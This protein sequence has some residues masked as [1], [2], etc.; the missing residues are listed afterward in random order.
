M[1]IRPA[2][3]DNHCGACFLHDISPFRELFSCMK[4]IVDNDTQVLA[5]NPYW[6]Y[7]RDMYDLPDGSRA[8]Y[9]Y[10]R[11]RGSVVAIPRC[12]DGNFIVVRQYRH[13]ARK[14]GVEFPGGGRKQGCTAEESARGE[15]REEAGITEAKLLPIGKFYPCVGIADEECAVFVADVAAMQAA[16]PERTEL[17]ET[18][19]VSEDNICH[20]IEQGELWNGM[21]LAAWA[22]FCRWRD[23]SSQ[24]L[25]LSLF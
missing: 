20:F 17:C 15:L 16:A 4:V 18:L 14:F 22:V 23:L 8:P 6:D 7:A 2:V 19:V 13:L 3:V 1:T 24:R 10:V 21:S 11:S 12:S 9:Y 25:Q 5:T